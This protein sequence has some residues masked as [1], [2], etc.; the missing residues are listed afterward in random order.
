ML[1]TQEQRDEMIR[2]WDHGRRS[3]SQIAGIMGVTKNAIVGRMRREKAIRGIE[4]EN[5]FAHRTRS[6]RV[7]QPKEK[8]KA[9]LA[10]RAGYFESKPFTPTIPKPDLGQLASIVDVVGCRW[11]VV[12][13]AAYVGGVAF[14]N[15]ATDGDHSYCPYHRQESVASYSR[16]LINKTTRDALNIYIKRA[17]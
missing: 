8:K 16:K 7:Y 5:Q 6:E 4:V 1:W 14:C 3:Y 2:L 9:T 10:L 15:H 12:D 17:A 13:D 11:P